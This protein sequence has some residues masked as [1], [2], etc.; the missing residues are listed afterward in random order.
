MTVSTGVMAAA[1]LPLAYYAFAIVTA[2]RFA[3]RRPPPPNPSSPAISILKPVR[4]P[5]SGAYG[6]YASFCRQHYPEYEVLFGVADA[7]DPAIAVIRRVIDDLPGARI[8]LIYPIPEDGPNAK[9]SIVR[10]L[11]AEARNDLLVIADSDVCAP[12]SLLARIAAPFAD[13]TVGAVTCLYRGERAGSPLASDLEALGIATEFMPGVLVAER[14]EG[15]RFALGAVMAAPRARVDEIG[16]FDVLLDRCADDFEFGRRVAA[17]G[18]AV[19]LSDAIV[20]T[21]CAPETL[22]AFLRHE[23]RWAIAQRQSRPY[24]WIG[25]ILATQGL[26]WCI[27]AAGVAPSGI[28]AALYLAGYVTLRAGLAWT[29]GVGILDDDTVRR[30]WWLLPLLDAIVCGVSIAAFSTNRVEWRGRRFVLNRGRLLPR[31]HH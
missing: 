19:R 2:R 17:R 28:V 30:R 7:D 23:L 9:M 26:P 4:G 15:I 13:S 16:G 5:D 6:R 18:Y 8:R 27:A 14:I 29:V 21:A 20:S 24:A 22:A 1:I 10:R 31:V 11:A 25:K 12:A 3:R